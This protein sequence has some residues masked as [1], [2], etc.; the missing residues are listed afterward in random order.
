MSSVFGGSKSKSSNQGYGQ[1]SQAL[2]P[3]MGFAQ[4]GGNAMS[5]LLGGDATGFNKFKNAT[6]FDFAAEQ[7]SHGI[8][9]NAAARGLL[10]SGGT[11]KSLMDFGTKLQDQYA[12]NYLEKLLGLGNLGLGA[13]GAIGGAGQT[14]KSKSKPGI[15]GFLGSVAGGMAA[16]DRRLKKDIKFI[17]TLPSGLNL[18]SYNYVDVD[19]PKIK[20]YMTRNHIGV[21][22]DEVKSLMPEALGPVI[23]GYMTVD[24]SKIGGV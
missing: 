23:D 7:G 11:G 19:S 3:T 15:G 20:K 17:R 1:I 16:S 12:G 2:G 5:A 22:A 24:Y 18:Y 9:G 4:Q 13:A 6:G 14:S 21:M 8:T 10:R